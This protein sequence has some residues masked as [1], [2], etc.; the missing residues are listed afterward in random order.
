MILLSL[1]TFNAKSI[2][3]SRMGVLSFL[4]IAAL[5]QQKI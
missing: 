5:Q 4:S 3:H 1:S 2:D